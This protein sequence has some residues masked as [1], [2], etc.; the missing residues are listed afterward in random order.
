MDFGK[1]PYARPFHV[2]D[3]LAVI[4]PSDKIR[5]LED[6]AEVVAGYLPVIMETHAR[7]IEEVLDKKVKRFRIHPEMRAHDWESRKLTP[8]IHPELLP[9]FKFSDLVETVYFEI[10]A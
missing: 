7:Q 3:F 1:V 8:P 9:D 6:G 10:Y 4:E 2:R 5:I